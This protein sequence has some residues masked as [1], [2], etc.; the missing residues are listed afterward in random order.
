M[1]LNTWLLGLKFDHSI[2]VFVSVDFNLDYRLFICIMAAHVTRMN[3]D[4]FYDKRGFR[5]TQN[6][7]TRRAF[8]GN[9]VL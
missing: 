7:V 6:I 4:I 1:A 8:T 9:N 5:F 3:V 2:M